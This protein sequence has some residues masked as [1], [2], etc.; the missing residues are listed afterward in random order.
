MEDTRAQRVRELLET[1][2]APAFYRTYMW[3]QAAAEARELQ[4]NECQQCK[5]RGLYSP[6]EQVHHKAPLL[7]AP[8]LAL[9]QSNLECLCKR[10]HEDR[11][12]EMHRG[13]D[14]G[15]LPAERW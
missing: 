2:G 14:V 7:R 15:R 1:G 8:H 10:C 12:A 6:A 5:R 3:Q 4:H 11:H 9:A 13:G